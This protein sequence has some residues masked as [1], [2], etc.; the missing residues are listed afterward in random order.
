[1]ACLTET[2]IWY[3]AYGKHKFEYSSGLDRLSANILF[4]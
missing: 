1:M 4:W 3:V 2:L